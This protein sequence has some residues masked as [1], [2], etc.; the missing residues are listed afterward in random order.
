MLWGQSWKVAWPHFFSW[1]LT[2][3][4][5]MVGLHQEGSVLPQ[6]TVSQQGLIGTQKPWDNVWRRFR[7]LQLGGR[8]S[9]CWHQGVSPGV[10]L[11]NLAGGSLV[12]KETIWGSQPLC[13]KEEGPCGSF[14]NASCWKLWPLCLGCVETEAAEAWKSGGP[15]GAPLLLQES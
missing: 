6:G 4:Q 11:T 12:T 14:L 2:E 7:L 15:P 1:D 8:A 13:M 9:D 5:L 3:V 10:S